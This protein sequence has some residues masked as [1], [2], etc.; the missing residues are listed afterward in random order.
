MAKTGPEDLNRTPEDLEAEAAAD[1]DARRHLQAAGEG[2]PWGN[3]GAPPYEPGAVQG[4]PQDP[5]ALLDPW[6]VTAALHR[7][8]ERISPS[9]GHGPTAF[10]W[11]GSPAEWP[12]AGG[13]G[14]SAPALPSGCLDPRP[15]RADWR[16][17]WRAVGPLAPDRLVVLVGP[18]GRGKT[19]FAVQA[20]EA[21]AASGAPVLYASAELGPDELL[22]RLLAVRAVGRVPWRSVLYGIV[23]HGEVNDAGR[24][25]AS[26]APG[27][28]LWAP[29]VRDRT[30][31]AL[32]GMAAAV[33]ELH[34][35]AP[36]VVVD[37]VQRFAP[38]GADRRGEVADLSGELRDLARPREGYPGA[39]VLA[40][41]STARDKYEK[42]GTALVLYKNHGAG[43]DGLVGTGK[44]TGELEYD[45]NAV[46][47]LTADPD[48]K[49]DGSRRGLLAAAKVRELA[50]GLA[51]LRFYAARGLWEGDPSLVDEL[52]REA[53]PPPTGNGNAGGG[54][55]PK[56]AGRGP[57]PHARG[58]TMP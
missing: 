2:E 8:M 53:A 23:D 49:A 44:E 40:L 14:A 31:K 50:P 42:M 41:S 9:G 57:R 29:R 45:A 36:L 32:Q 28:Y 5:A 12:E 25:L 55:G 20:A 47:V 35:A 56:S 46:A 13:E 37:Y 52:A 58:E 54:K 4:A 33:A 1:A 43:P 16:D 19:A 15:R 18:T 6:T 11:P 38:T 24:I 7:L 17:V 48:S 34:G 51:G 22:A 27:L 30:G 21:V 26:D 10:P 3:P 39:G